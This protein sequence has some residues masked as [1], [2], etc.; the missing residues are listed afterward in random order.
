[1]ERFSPLGISWRPYHLERVTNA[2]SHIINNSALIRFG[3]TSSDKTLEITSHSNSYQTITAYLVSAITYLPHA[4]IGKFDSAIQLETYGPIYDYIWICC[5]GVIVSEL[6][7]MIICAYKSIENLYI[8][9]A[10]F[11]IFLSS[12]WSYRMMLGPWNEVPFLGFYLLSLLLFW[13]RL[14]IAGIASYFIAGLISWLWSLIISFFFILEYILSQIFSGRRQRDLN[15]LPQGFQSKKER[16]IYIM[17]GIIPTLIH[18]SSLTIARLSDTIVRNTGSSGI[19]RIG[20]DSLGN[21]HHGGILAAMQFL[22]GN[23][24][25]V[26]LDKG[27]TH[28]LYELSGKIGLYNCGLSIIGMLCLSL[29]SV[30][31]I[32][33][34]AKRK[35]ETLW[36]FIPLA[37][38]FL[39]FCMLFQQ[40]LAVHLLGH[41]FIF[42]YFF[43]LGMIGII[44]IVA[45]K[46]SSRIVNQIIFSMPCVIGV[47]IT[48]ARVSYLTGVNG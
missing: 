36:A 29:V 6:S 22:G 2:I 4:V 37:W 26:C 19:N 12:P 25:S 20:L 1:M 47:I 33:F 27:Y 10:T 3:F 38:T 30:V 39:S 32:I 13:K 7:I 46:L 44:K 48:S 15:L 24:L 34:L 21:I 8:G 40:S 35:R 5:I 14:K 31:G 16:M 17:I 43:A 11:I 9:P 18:F 23:R 28:G 45:S 42:S 41:S